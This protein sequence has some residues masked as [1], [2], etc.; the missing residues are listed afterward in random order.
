LAILWGPDFTEQTDVSPPEGLI[1][2]G[3]VLAIGNIAG[4]SSPDIVGRAGQVQAVVNA[5]TRQFELGG[6]TT[7]SGQITATA[8]GQFTGD[9]Q[10][11]LSLLTIQ[12][13]T[14]A[15]V[16]AGNGDGTFAERPCSSECDI[17]LAWSMATGDFDLD[18]KTDLGIAATTGRVHVLLGRGDGSFLSNDD[19]AAGDSA[20][21]VA[22][23]DL[24][25][26]QVLDLAVSVPESDEVALL[27]GTGNGLFTALP[28]LS[29]APSRTPRALAL[30]DVNND[31]RPDIIVI[32]QVSE[33][34][35]VFVSDP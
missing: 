32:N 22:T 33:D 35:V 24:D 26:D 16:F 29:V 12:S 6:T 8:L 4:D 10:L 13:G 9:D 19:F 14:H 25:G 21:S 31:D 18:G 5:G 20:E 11:D 27:R 7:V 17:P 23:A 30:G 3:D 34:V 15:K 28:K 2:A 1:F